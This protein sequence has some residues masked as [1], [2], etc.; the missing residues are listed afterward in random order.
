[1]KTI[2]KNV[3]ENVT[4]RTNSGYNG[5][6]NYETWLVALWMDNSQSDQQYYR[7]LAEG[8]SVY[9]LAQVIQNEIEENSPLEGGSMYEDLL[10][11]ALS[12][13]D[14]YE[15]AENLKSEL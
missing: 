4:E 10:R 7:E 12:E 6:K 11:A 3:T 5:W 13:V 15:I 14:F 8:M 2:I 9:D 1:M